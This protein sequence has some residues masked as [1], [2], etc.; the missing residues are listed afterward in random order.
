M[1]IPARRADR[2]QRSPRRQSR[3]NPAPVQAMENRL[4][5]SEQAQ[6]DHVLPALQPRQNHALPHLFRLTTLQSSYNKIIFKHAKSKQ[7]IPTVRTLLPQKITHRILYAPSYPV[8][9]PSLK[10]EFAKLS[11][12][13]EHEIQGTSSDI[14]SCK[15]AHASK[16]FEDV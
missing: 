2:P 14:R 11:D 6:E 16:E 15:E 7:E 5:P 1:H 10:D 4:L 8:S 13:I 3:A 12:K 9:E